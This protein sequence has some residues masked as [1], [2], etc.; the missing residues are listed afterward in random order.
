VAEG[1]ADLWQKVVN[2]LRGGEAAAESLPKIW[3]NDIG[4][5]TN[6]TYTVNEAGMAAH[7]T[8]S[9]ADGKSQFLSGVDAEKAVLDA[10]A[11]ADKAGLWVDNTAKVFVENGPVGVIGKN[12]ELTN[13]INVYRR[14][15]G[16]VHGCPGGA[17]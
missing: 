7:K 13:W 8:G 12:G 11:Y 2:S 3:T 6:G 1:W 15:T 9:L 5:L 4:Q 16:F 17:P 10:A 14:E